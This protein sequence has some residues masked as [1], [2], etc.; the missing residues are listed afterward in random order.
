MKKFEKIRL[1][2]YGIVGLLIAVLLTGLGVK[3]NIEYTEE[4]VWKD[5]QSV[6][7]T[8]LGQ[9]ERSDAPLGVGVQ[10]ELHLDNLDSDTKLIFHASHCFVEVYIEDE[11]VYSMKSSDKINTVETTGGTWNIIPI[12][13]EDSGKT[14]TVV[15]MPAY[16]SFLNQTPS[17]MTGSVHAVFTSLFM[18]NLP[19]ILVTILVM[20]IGFIFI[21]FGLIFSVKAKAK[22]NILTLGFFAFV[23]SLWRFCDFNFITLISG[24]KNIFIYY[25][26]ITMLM[27]SAI[28]LLEAVKHSFHGKAQKAFDVLSLI[29]GITSIV[30]LVLQL[31]DITDMREI[32]ILTH[33][34]ILASLV[35]IL[36]CLIMQLIRPAVKRSFN[37]AFLIILGIGTDLLLFYIKDSSDG[38]IF[39]LLSILVFVL[40][41]GMQFVAQYIEQ[42]NRLIES[43]I[44]IAHNEAK[45]AENR[46]T[47]MMSQIRSHFVF[48]ILN[49]IS[50]MCKYDPEKADK[51]IVHFARFL[52]SNIDIMQNDDLVH[53]HNALHHLEDYI[54]LEQVRYGDKIQFETDIEVDNFMLP[55]LVIQPVV[56]NSIKHGLVSK[57]SGGTITLRT[58]KDENNIYIIIEDDGIGYDSSMEISEKSIGLQNIKFRLSHMVNG[59]LNAQSIVNIGTKTTITIPRKEAEKCE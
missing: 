48:N 53:F 59:S 26:S 51:T 41:E 4:R 34:I 33:L 44:T 12:F 22:L 2:T 37:P 16:E 17:F 39:T 14:C 9:I 35:L 8:N 25:I 36:A 46:F 38:L 42:Q 56:E 47:M 29:I 54:A 43:E 52:R 6:V 55:P 49:A 5:T 7:Y 21:C 40:I 19:E 30:Q 45:L 27:I 10:Y 24:D 28:P 20:F 23:V 50:G 15:L 58:R 1:I 31:L 32:L 3:S 13:R 11:L 57:P 18:S